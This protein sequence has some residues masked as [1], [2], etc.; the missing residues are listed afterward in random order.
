MSDE[1]IKERIKFLKKM[2][3]GPCGSFKARVINRDILERSEKWLDEI[4]KLEEQLESS[5]DLPIPDVEL[6]K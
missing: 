6:D 2:V 5:N 4:E 3:N 1:E